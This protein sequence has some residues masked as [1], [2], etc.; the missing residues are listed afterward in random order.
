MALRFCPACGARLAFSNQRFCTSCGTTLPEGAAAHPP[1]AAGAG[2]GLKVA[3]IAVAILLVVGGG[4]FHLFMNPGS[5]AGSSVARAGDG[6]GGAVIPSPAQTPVTPLTTVPATTK[7]IPVPSA[8]TTTVPTT[9]PTT[10]RTP[11]RTPTRPPTTAVTIP[12]IEPEA[13][14]TS[15]ITLAVT[16][17]SAQPPASSYTSSTEGAPYISPQTLER[18]VHE[19]INEQRQENGLSSLSYDPFLADI[20]RGHSWDMVNRNF[21]EHENPDGQSPRDRGDAAGYPCIRVMG[22]FVYSGISENLYQG[23]RASSYY[24][25]SAGEIVSYD[26]RTLDEIAEVAVTGW[27]NSPGHRQNILT[28]HFSYEGIGVAF[29]PDDKVYI[30]ENFC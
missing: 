3:I 4:A 26:W 7:T 23:N 2:G 14:T 24:T 5:G 6:N 20:A 11:V 15:A 8:V 1:V 10:T 16:Q 25:N 22:H 13:A 29:A 28:S 9:I 30:T 19:L 21:F 18:R 12:A 17:V 27:M